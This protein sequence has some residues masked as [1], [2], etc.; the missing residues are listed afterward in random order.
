M[1]KVKGKCYYVVCLI[2]M[3]YM[4]M[5]C[6]VTDRVE[7]AVQDRMPSGVEETQEPEASQEKEEKK[8][9]KKKA[10]KKKK[11]TSK[12]VNGMRPKFKKAMDSYEK[13]FN[14]YIK[15]MKKYQKSPT[16]TDLLTDYADYMSQHSDTMAKMEQLENDNLNSAEIS[17]Y[18]KVTARIME[19]LA[20]VAQ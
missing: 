14:K 11:S 7:E 15:F 20:K 18:A 1:K 4:M 19:K 10:K 16:D 5:G 3:A 9:V 8:A 17:Y 6:G 13:F 12:L 2:V